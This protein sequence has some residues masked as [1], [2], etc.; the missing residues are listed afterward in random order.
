MG[1]CK[2][3]IDDHSVE[4]AMSAWLR[5]AIGGVAF[6][7]GLVVG[8]WVSLVWYR[9]DWLISPGI[10]ALNTTLLWMAGALVAWGTGSIFAMAL[11]A[12]QRL[13]H[14]TSLTMALSVVL[15]LS[16]HLFLMIKGSTFFFSQDALILSIAG[17]FVGVAIV[18]LH[19][20]R[21]GA[22]SA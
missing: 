9:A 20:R 17:G 13:V 1:E 21:A 16:P 4:S 19:R 14:S 6:V 11:Y 12:V 10:S 18:L 8:Y 15:P 5:S 3:A 7:L 22:Q 2:G